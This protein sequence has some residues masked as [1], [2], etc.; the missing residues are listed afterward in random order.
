VFTDDQPSAEDELP[1]TDALRPLALDVTLNFAIPPDE[2]QLFLPLTEVN[3]RV[4]KPFSEIGTALRVNLA[5]LLSTISMPYTMAH[6]SS[7]DRHWQRIHSAERIRSLMLNAEP[8]ETQEALQQRRDRQAL[9]RARS[10]MDEFVHSLEGR[11]AIIGDTLHFLDRLRSDESLGGAARELILQGAVL[12]WGAFEVFSPD[13]FIAH[14][15]A[16]PGCTLAL[17]GDPVA[18]RRF[19]LSKVSLAT[20]AAHKFGLSERMGTLLAQQ[21]DLSDIYSVKSVY[22]ALFTH[23][24]N[25][26][27]ALNDPDLRLLSLRRN[28]IVHQRGVIDQSYVD[29]AN[30][31]Q[32]VGDRL[33]LTPS[34]LESHLRTSIEVAVAVLNAVSKAS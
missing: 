11:S 1:Q 18:K 19:E 5:G 22:Q 34:D 14:L 8:H 12:C 15:N 3:L 7:L 32:R 33:K 23:N 6:K 29:S 30:T 31:S 26:S 2:N 17:L 4:G 27:E 13:C 10:M 28:L 21:Q 9:T 25:L 20:L 24:E 16:N